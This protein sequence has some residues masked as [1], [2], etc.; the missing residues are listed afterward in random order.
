VAPRSLADLHQ[1]A[2]IAAA[3]RPT[4]FSSRR[5]WSPPGAN[6]GRSGV[7]R[8]WRRPAGAGWAKKEADVEAK[9]RTDE[10][11]ASVTI[12]A[13]LGFAASL[14]VEVRPTSCLLLVCHELHRGNN[15]KVLNRHLIAVAVGVVPL[16]SITEEPERRL[17]YQP[18]FRENALLVELDERVVAVVASDSVYV[19]LVIA[20][21]KKWRPL[22]RCVLRLTCHESTSI[23]SQSQRLRMRAAT[24]HWLGIAAC[25]RLAAVRLYASPYDRS[26]HYAVLAHGLDRK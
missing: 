23:V 4:A 24:E 12:L 2:E 8:Y 14:R 5:V 9:L 16:D 13:A 18:R 19:F 21:N 11:Y 25:A 15:A 20:E 7:A 10:T 1:S 3:R 6:D 17:R 22:C 26:A